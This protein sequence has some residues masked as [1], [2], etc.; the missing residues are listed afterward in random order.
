MLEDTLLILCSD[1]GTSA[2]GG[3]LGSLNE[4][5]FTHDRTDDIADTLAHIDELGGFRAY[6]HYAWGWAWAG[7]APFRLWKRYTWLGG[8]RTPLIVH[9][10]RRLEAPGAVRAQFCH[11]VDIM[12]TVVDAA[13]IEQP[14]TVDGERQQPVDGVS[15]V[16]TFAD[17]GAPTPRRTQ[18]FEMI[19]SRA[20]YHDGWKA[21][22]NHVGRQLTVERDLL[23][24]SLDFETDRW[25][26]FD[27]ERDFSEA[28]D[29]AAAHP[30]RVRRL[31]QLWWAEAGRN[32][33]LPIDDT[34]IGRA[35]AMVPSPWGHRRRAVYHPG[36][37]A[38]AEDTLPPMV[39]G[40]RML[41]D[42]EVGERAEGILVAL[43]DWNNGFACYLLDGALVAAFNLF[44]E[45]FRI[46]AEG[47]VATG[48]HTMGIEYERRPAGGG[49]VALSVDGRSVGAGQLPGD[50]PFRW[51]IGG[52]GLLVGHDRG[53][54]VCDDYRPPFPFT[55]TIRRV[56]IE[57]PPAS[58]RGTAVEVRDALRHE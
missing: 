2:E 6:N 10:P 7:N 55:G 44:G 27:L 40:F 25:E 57:A 5:R 42:V 56:T 20:I 4:H 24:G 43:G 29:L 52:T 53:F 30:E 47:R 21:T 8:V 46:V 33:V 51:Q 38:V 23:E 13:G 16:P 12:P 19:G 9:W 14:A 31:E 49:P 36:G 15:L 39:S 28:R 41:A 11:A 3:P 17:A 50:L 34:F 54:P 37:G 48:E 22:T 1:N 58:P 18:Y 45:L 26:L 32:Q 35:I